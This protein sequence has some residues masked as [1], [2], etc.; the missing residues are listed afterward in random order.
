MV[1]QVLH[2]E[3]E[4]LEV[5]RQV[6]M[7]SL[8]AGCHISTE[9]VGVRGLIHTGSDSDPYTFFADPD[10]G[11]KTFFKGNNKNFRGK[12]CFQPKK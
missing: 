7:N 1:F 6:E 5:A 11:K 9:G 12:F 2:V 3:V 8:Q 4:L 10:P